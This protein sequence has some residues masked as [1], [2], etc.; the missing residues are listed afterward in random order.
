MTLLEHI[1]R[2]LD[3]IGVW[4]SL[5]NATTLRIHMPVER[6]PYS[7]LE[8]WCGRV[9]KSGLYQEHPHLIT[10]ENCGR[11]LELL[12]VPIATMISSSIG[13]VSSTPTVKSEAIGKRHWVNS[14]RWYKG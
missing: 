4:S 5:M 2:D 6:E 9:V 7:A 11:Y 8:E 10:L 13:I 14:R 3:A 12:A 1:Q